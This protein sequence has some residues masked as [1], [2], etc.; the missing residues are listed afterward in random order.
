LTEDSRATEERPLTG[1]MDP[2]F[3]PVRVGDTVRRHPGPSGEVV[4]E[5]LLHLEAVGFDGAPR[6]LGTDDQGREVLSWIDGDVPLPPY[7]AWSMTDRALADLGALVRRLHDATASFHPSP[8]RAADWPTDWADPAG[9]ST[10]CHND[11]FPENVVFRNGRV[12][13]LIDFA[14]AAPGRPLWDVAIAAETWGPLGDPARRDQHPLDLDGIARLGVLARGYGVETGRGEDLVAVLIEERAH[15]I[16]NIQAE[17]AAGNESWIGNWAAAG[18][19]ERA[20]ADD[21]WIAAN[22]ARLIKAAGENSG[23][24]RSGPA[25]ELRP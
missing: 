15:S 3:A 22:R 4:R 8:G 1:S 18:G 10:I 11:L 13:A 2:R 7:P 14:M 21:A 16:A 25:V 17:I 20:A 24:A 19:D 12:V 9:G 6:H 5:L 23:P